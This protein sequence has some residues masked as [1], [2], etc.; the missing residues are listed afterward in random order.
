MSLDKI[1]MPSEISL[2][3]CKKLQKKTAASQVSD[4][5]IYCSWGSHH[6]LITW[7]NCL[8]TVTS[9]WLIFVKG[10]LSESK[11]QKPFYICKTKDEYQY[12]GCIAHWKMSFMHEVKNSSCHHVY[13]YC[14]FTH[15]LKRECLSEC[16]SCICGTY[17]VHHFTGTQWKIIQYVV[18][19]HCTL[20]WC[21]MQ[22]C[23]D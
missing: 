9:F 18:L 21:T 2:S 12:L 5:L 3:I 14:T 16:L 13:M 8:V 15:T 17:D 4:I 7:R 10:S 20:W 1:H 6:F 11:S 19:Y 23:T 22:L